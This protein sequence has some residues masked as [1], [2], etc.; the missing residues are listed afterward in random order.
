MIKIILIISIIINFYFGFK[1]TTEF[2]EKINIKIEQKQK[3][4]IIY[5]KIKN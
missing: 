1:L 3:E 4:V 2:L 5:T